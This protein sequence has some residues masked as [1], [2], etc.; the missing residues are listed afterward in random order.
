MLGSEIFEYRVVHV[1]PLEHEEHRAD[2]SWVLKHSIACHDITEE[3]A[4]A[5]M[6]HDNS[7]WTDPLYRHLCLSGGGPSKCTDAEDAKRIAKNLTRTLLGGGMREAL[8]YRWKAMDHGLAF[9]ARGRAAHELLPRALQ[10]MWSPRDIAK[11]RE[12]AEVA[13]NTDELSFA[14]KSAVNA[15]SVLRFFTNDP[16]AKLI[17]EAQVGICWD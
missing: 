16:G 17:Y 10:R 9:L 1:L 14:T 8:A 15:G 2:A 7:A 3:D 12:E 13:L 6:A 4:A 11:A 5:I